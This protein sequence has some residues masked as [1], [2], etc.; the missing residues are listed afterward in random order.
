M[1]GD[2]ELPPCAWRRGVQSSDIAAGCACGRSLLLKL[3]LAGRTCKEIPEPQ[4]RRVPS[5]ASVLSLVLQMGNFV[6]TDTCRCDGGRFGTCDEHSSGP[7]LLNLLRCQSLNHLICQLPNAVKLKAVAK[8]GGEEQER[9][10][11]WWKW[12]DGA[13]LSAESLFLPGDARLGFTAGL[14]QELPGQSCSLGTRAG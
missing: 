2:T 4:T 13:A 8:L 9:E 3:V 10:E 6:L 5:A 7:M 14:S 12:L 11:L 1:L